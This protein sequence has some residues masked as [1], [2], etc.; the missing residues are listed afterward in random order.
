MRWKACLDEINRLEEGECV[1]AC[2]VVYGQGDYDVDEL[3]N[4]ADELMYENKCELKAA[5]KEANS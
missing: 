4:R 3:L 1:I 2:G 5:E